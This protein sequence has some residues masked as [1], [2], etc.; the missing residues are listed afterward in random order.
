MSSNPHLN[1]S[2]SQHNVP[3]PKT[4]LDAGRCLLAAQAKYLDASKKRVALL[5][6]G[7]KRRDKLVR[8]AGMDIPAAGRIHHLSFPEG[9]RGS[10]L[11]SWPPWLS[12]SPRP[13][14]HMTPSSPGCI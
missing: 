7:I 1:A 5:D 14:L 3:A 10:P 6:E 4:E 9:R 12:V 13:R 2:N 11:S 8:L